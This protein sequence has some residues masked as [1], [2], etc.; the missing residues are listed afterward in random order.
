MG[1]VRAGSAADFRQARQQLGARALADGPGR[2]DR[3]R[4]REQ[5]VPQPV[6]VPDEQAG[7][8]PAGGDRWASGGLVVAFVEKDGAS[9]HRVCFRVQTSELHGVIAQLLVLRQLRRRRRRRAAAHLL[10]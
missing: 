8:S 4:P 7:G 10:M 2:V 9:G 6:E 5:S 3:A 1:D